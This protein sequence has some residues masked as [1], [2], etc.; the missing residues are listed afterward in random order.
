MT[1]VAVV[2][3]GFRLSEEHLL[4]KHRLLDEIGKTY[5]WSVIK[6]CGY[7]SLL[8]EAIPSFTFKIT[9]TST[10][11]NGVH[12]RFSLHALS[13][14]AQTGHS[15]Q[16]LHAGALSLSGVRHD[17]SLSDLSARFEPALWSVTYLWPWMMSKGDR[18]RR[19]PP[20]YEATADR[21]RHCVP[22]ESD[23]GYNW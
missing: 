2:A 22:A 1:D 10:S 9:S 19:R 8:A 16:R 21:P 7:M 5:L 3:A 6:G 15:L 13:V 14:S 17:T 18:P 23:N 4:F 11:I 20:G 12:C